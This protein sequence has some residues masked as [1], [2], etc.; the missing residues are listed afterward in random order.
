MPLSVE[1]YGR[2]GQP[3][4]ELLNVLATVA[5]ASGFVDKAAFVSN[6][7]RELGVALCRGQG[8]LFRAGLKT[9]ARASGVAF[10]AGASAPTAE[11]S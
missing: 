1:S 4:M 7:L 11:V 9:L 3:A 8:L 6:A 5:S 2:L 10:A